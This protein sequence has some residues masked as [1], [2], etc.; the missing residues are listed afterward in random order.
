MSLALPLAPE[1]TSAA[2]PIQ[3]LSMDERRRAMRQRLMQELGEE[4]RDSVRHIA[5][6]KGSD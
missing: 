1:T 4:A 2:L 5:E 6:G 3:P